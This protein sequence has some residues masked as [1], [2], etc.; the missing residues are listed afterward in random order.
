VETTSAETMS[1]ILKKEPPEP[2]E[3]TRNV[4]PG[5]ERVVCH[6]SEKN[7]AE[8]FQSAHDSQFAR[9]IIKYLQNG[10]PSGHYNVLIWRPI[11]VRG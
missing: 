5:L 4:N 2:S 7:P 6:C 10:S 3:T 11:T 8:R 1:A 9:S